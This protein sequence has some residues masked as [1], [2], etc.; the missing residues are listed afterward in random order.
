MYSLVSTPTLI[1]NFTIRDLLLVKKVVLQTVYREFIP[2]DVVKV[3]S[4]Q[5]RDVLAI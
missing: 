2:T 1:Q 5:E 4:L 3:V